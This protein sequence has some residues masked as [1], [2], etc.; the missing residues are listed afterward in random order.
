MNRTMSGLAALS[1]GAL[2]LSACGLSEDEGSTE[3]VAA[4]SVDSS[5]LEGASLSVGSKDFDEQL[6]LGQ[7]TIQMLS[8]AGAEVT[9]DTNIQGSTATRQALLRGEIDVYYDYTGTGWITYLKHTE[10][11][12]D[13]QE[14]YQA[15]AKEDLQKNG[16]VW[17]EP[18][19]FNNTYAMAVTE[20]F[21]EENGVE[22]LSDMATYLSDNPD[23]TVCVESEFAARPDGLPGMEK[24]YNMDIPESSIQSLGTGVI[25]Q[26]IDQGECDFGEVF[27]TDGRIATLGLI[28]LEDDKGFF[29]LYNG[30]PIVQQE[31]ENGEAILEVLQP[32]SETLTTEVMSELN[33]KVSSEGLPPEDVASDYLTEEGFI[34]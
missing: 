32:L 20:E 28:P 7:L 33:A 18:A 17:G 22:T 16:L 23:A 21:A 30:A 13:P 27:T 34:E 24:A 6:L 11:I 1:A 19:P 25:Y 12:A 26:Q 2:L 15:V 4:G 9:D 5:A 29:P 31:N 14:L 10:N 3:E 8:A